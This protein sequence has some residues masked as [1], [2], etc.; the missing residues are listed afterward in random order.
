MI[1]PNIKGGYILLSRTLIESQ[2]FDKPPLYL[3]VWIYLL[4]KAQHKDFKRLK[5]G[6]LWTSISEIR[7]AC[8]WYVGYRKETPTKKQIYTI[9]EWLR[10]P[11]KWNRERTEKGTM[12][13]TTKG[14]QGMLININ[15]YSFYQDPKNYEGNNQNKNEETTKELRMEQHG[16]NINKNYNNVQKYNENDN[17]EDLT[18]TTNEAL[19]LCKYW[20]TLKP[21]ESICK[22]MA[23]LKMFIQKYGY[24]WTEEAMKIMVKNK[25]RF[26]PKY[27][28]VILEDWYQNGKYDIP[29]KKNYQ[30]ESTFNNFKQRNY[31]FKEL[32]RKLL[33]WDSDTK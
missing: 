25:N 2:I 12:I 23:T 28:E 17:K 3:K 4:S 15:K 24:D 9:L 13:E 30:K 20:E 21:S 7:E 22:H 1:E 18:L 31:D 33:G 26:I 8:N 27:I 29:K 32:E 5:R 11:C 16:N 6:E 10:N 14:T 19:E